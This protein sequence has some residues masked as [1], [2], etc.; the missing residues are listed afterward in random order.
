[1]TCR[2]TAK[3]PSVGRS[4]RREPLEW[5]EAVG[6]IV[7]SLGFFLVALTVFLVVTHLIG[8]EA[9]FDPDKKLPR[10]FARKKREVAQA[11]MAFAQLAEVG[12]GLR[13]V[14]EASEVDVDRALDTWFRSLCMN[15]AWTLATDTHEVYRVCIWTADSSDQD[16]LRALAWHMMP[17]HV[18]TWQTL[19]KNTSLAG[20]A[21]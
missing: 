19:N 7:K 9:E 3:R 16:V 20:K 12:K 1:M 17:D 11:S 8:Y 13:G 4:G 15:V 18:P 14:V 10:V 5:V 21:M 6:A 2:L